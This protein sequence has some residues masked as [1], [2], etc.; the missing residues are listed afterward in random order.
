M[1]DDYASDESSSLASDEWEV[2][3]I[4]LFNQKDFRFHVQWGSG[5]KSWEDAHNFTKCDG[6]KEEFF[7]RNPL[8]CAS[9]KAEDIQLRF[10]NERMLKTHLMKKHKLKDF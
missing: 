9:C 3:S 5:E 8:F 7:R 1:S 10:Q 2:S 4:L 6:L